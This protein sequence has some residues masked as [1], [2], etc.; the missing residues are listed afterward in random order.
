MTDLVDFLTHEF[1]RLGR[2]RLA[3]TPVPAGLRD[4]SLVGHDNSPST[5]RPASFIAL[6]A[7]INACAGAIDPSRLQSGHAREPGAPGS[8][9][10]VHA[11]RGHVGEDTSER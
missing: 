5:G 1:A 4:R 9:D 8:E 10:H 6:L 2:G 11:S 7:F 3:G